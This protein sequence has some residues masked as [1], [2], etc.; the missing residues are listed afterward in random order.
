VL[1]SYLHDFPLRPWCLRQL[2]LC[3]RITQY[4]IFDFAE[5]HFHEVRLRTS[6][7]TE[8]ST[9]CCG[10]QNDKKYESDHGN[11]EDEKILGP[12]NLTKKNK[13]CLWNIKLKQWSSIDLNKG[14]A[15]E[16]QKIDHTQPGTDGIKFSRR[17]I[18]IDPV[19]LSLF[20]YGSDSISKTFSERFIMMYNLTHGSSATFKLS[21]QLSQHLYKQ[22]IRDHFELLCYPLLSTHYSP[23]ALPVAL[24]A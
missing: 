8:E 1:G 16:N 24:L 4:P 5:H 9:E 22:L 12:E 14:E 19:S 17:L 3:G 21:L 10:K 13:F 11:A 15:K 2:A 7:A 20:V 18:S 6:P 23:A